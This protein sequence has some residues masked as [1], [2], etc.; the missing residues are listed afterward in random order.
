[1][2][3]RLWI[4]CVTKVNDKMGKFEPRKWRGATN[5][6][7]MSEQT[8]IT[9]PRTSIFIGRTMDT[10]I[11]SKRFKDLLKSEAT[12]YISCLCG[13]MTKHSQKCSHSYLILAFVFVHS[14]YSFLYV[15]HHFSFAPQ[16]QSIQ[17]F[18]VLLLLGWSLLNSASAQHEVLAK[19]P[20]SDGAVNRCVL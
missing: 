15:S 13:W 6:K 1:M 17:F 16:F 14:S 19:Q 5:D 8:K 20:F 18:L 7:K 12:A 10:E 11:Q 4:N 9:Y 3:Q 2:A